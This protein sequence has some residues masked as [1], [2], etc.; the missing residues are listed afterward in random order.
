MFI[1][2]DVAE[3]IVKIVNIALWPEFLGWLVGS[4]NFYFF[5][6]RLLWCFMKPQVS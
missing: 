2:A 4:G 6:S 1:E 3:N 5:F